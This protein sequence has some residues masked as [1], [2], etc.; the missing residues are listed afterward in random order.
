MRSTDR[1]STNSISSCISTS[2]RE[3]FTSCCKNSFSIPIFIPLFFRSNRN[4]L[5]FSIYC[6]LLTIVLNNYSSTLCYCKISKYCSSVSIILFIYFLSCFIKN[7]STFDSINV[8]FPTSNIGYSELFI[9]R[10]INSIIIYIIII[11]REVTIVIS[12]WFYMIWIKYYI[13]SSR[14]ICKF[15]GF[16]INSF[17]VIWTI[18]FDIFNYNSIFIIILCF[19]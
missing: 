19:L 15:I 7:V 1:L 11:F 13:I 4:N 12:S 14:I 9:W 10:I 18:I 5:A 6:I 3:F 16:W 2:S 17:L 8:L